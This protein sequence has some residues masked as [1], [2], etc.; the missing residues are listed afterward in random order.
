VSGHPERLDVEQLVKK[1]VI[2]ITIADTINVF[3]LIIFNCFWLTKYII[4]IL[5]HREQL[6]IPPLNIPERTEK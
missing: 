2:A 6:L 3:L 4:L 1:I 5:P